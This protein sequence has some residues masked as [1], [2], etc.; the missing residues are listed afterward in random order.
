VE[1]KRFYEEVSR[2]VIERIAAL[3]EVPSPVGKDGL[4]SDAS[5]SPIAG[6]RNAE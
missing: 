3:G 2:T 6:A 5:E 1:S 4:G